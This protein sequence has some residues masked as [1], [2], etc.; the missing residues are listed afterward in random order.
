MSNK[1]YLTFIYFVVLLACIMCAAAKAD[2]SCDNVIATCQALVKEQD[3]SITM[4]KT[5][6]SKDENQIVSDQNAAKTS[7]II[8][9]IIGLAA[10]AA[11]TYTIHH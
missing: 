9:I 6:L 4:L 3:T 5:Q 8:D 2:T 1:T 11:I 10:G 7:R